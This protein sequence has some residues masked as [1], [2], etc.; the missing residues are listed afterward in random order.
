MSQLLKI[1]QSSVKE[2]EKSKIITSAPIVR[3]TLM[4]PN[5]GLSF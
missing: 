4:N 1:H 2:N 5:K 3:Q